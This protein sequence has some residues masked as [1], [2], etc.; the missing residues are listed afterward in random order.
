MAT[1]T[2]FKKYEAPKSFNFTY[3][4]EKK[5]QRRCFSK[6]YSLH[7]FYSLEN[8]DLKKWA[9]QANEAEQELERASLNFFFLK[10]HVVFNQIY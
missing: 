9:G 1:K 10:T 7:P 3:F 4:S 8:L 5:K 2:V 6:Q